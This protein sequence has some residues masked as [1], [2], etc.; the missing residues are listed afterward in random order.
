M[1]RG[2]SNGWQLVKASWSVLRNDKKLMIFPLISM[3]ASLIVSITFIIPVVM[4]AMADSA[5]RSTE[6]DSGGMGVFSVVMMFLFY[7]VMNAVVFY[8]NSALVAAVMMRIRGEDMTLGKAFGVATQ[9]LPSILGYAA[10]SATVGVILR[11]IAERGIVGRIVTSL[12]G[13][14]WSIL[15]FLV[16][17]ILVVENINPIEA[18][19]R[20]GSLLKQTWGEQITGNLSMGFVFGLLI[21]ATIFLIGVPLIFIGAAANSAILLAMSIAGVV[22]LVVALIL[23]QSALQGIFTT[24]LYHYA[25]AG[26][27]GGLYDEALI[28]QA[29]RAK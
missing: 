18:V 22:V 12:L 7:L 29:F 6:S 2:F 21:V 26:T 10:I 1:F 4:A 11:S 9:R 16:V 5:T 28:Q 14:A 17:P 24:A 3:I 8:F 19:K 15:T 20:S 13:T 27:T 23:I 25:T